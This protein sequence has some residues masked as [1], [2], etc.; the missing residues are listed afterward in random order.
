MCTLRVFSLT[1]LF[2]GSRAGKIWGEDDDGV[3]CLALTFCFTRVAD[4]LA[5]IACMVLLSTKNHIVR[6]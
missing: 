1:T 5:E 2:G 6:T 3:I 4:P